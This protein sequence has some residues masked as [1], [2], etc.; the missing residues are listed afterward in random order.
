[1]K[2]EITNYPQFNQI[3]DSI[4]TDAIQYFDNFIDQKTC[5]E[6]ID[7]LDTN[8]SQ[9]NCQE[10]EL[11]FGTIDK[12]RKNAVNLS[13]ND[14]NK[15]LKALSDIIAPNLG[16][17]IRHYLMNLGYFGSQ[18]IELNDTELKKSLPRLPESM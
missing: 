13:F 11:G 9:G 6:C 15:K 14:N 4:N 17:F 10:G 7:L 12:N 8:E 1:M 5:N 2:L 16:I 18:Y 3:L